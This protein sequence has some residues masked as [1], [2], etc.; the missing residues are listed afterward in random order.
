LITSLGL[1]VKF[2]TPGTG[3]AD[4][5][6]ILDYQRSKLVKGFILYEA[7]LDVSEMTSW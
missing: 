7:E 4:A 1:L 5:G 6:V 2:Q 3:Q